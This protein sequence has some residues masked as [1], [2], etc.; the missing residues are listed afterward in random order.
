[1]K[2]FSLFLLFSKSVIS[3][4]SI[5]KHLSR[6]QLTMFCCDSSGYA[7]LDI[8]VSHYYLFFSPRITSSSLAAIYAKQIWHIILPMLHLAVPTM[9]VGILHWWLAP[10][11][12]AQQP[13]TKKG[14]DSA[15]MLTNWSLWKERNVRQRC[16]PGRSIS[17]MEHYV[18]CSDGR[19]MN[20]CWL[21]HSTYFL[22][23]TCY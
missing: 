23:V 21:V 2:D 9:H 6:V 11:T 10:P 17:D 3:G 5:S 16:W 15:V 14:V 4:I 13:Q 1:M 19:L 22:T 8:S 18:V 12:R 7:P 20:Q